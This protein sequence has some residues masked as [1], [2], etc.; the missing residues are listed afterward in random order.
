MIAV[1]VWYLHGMRPDDLPD[2]LAGLRRASRGRDLP[3]PTLLRSEKWD[4]LVRDGENE[5][6][7]GLVPLRAMAKT[8]RGI[9]TGANEFFHLTAAQAR[10][11]GLP[12]RSLLPCV[13]R[14]GDV[15]GFEFTEES[16]RRIRDG[17]ARCYLVSLGPD[18]DDAERRYIAA[19]ESEGIQSRYLLA[20]RRP[21]F[22]MERQVPAPVWAAVFGRQ[23][24]RFVH[25]RAGVRTL[26]T[27][28]CVYPQTAS[29]EFC[30]ALTLC[31]NA[32]STQNRARAQR[33]VYGGGLLKFEPKDLL[34]IEVPDLRRVS[35][36]ILAELAKLQAG[37]AGSAKRISETDWARADEA[38]REAAAEAA[39][40][41]ARHA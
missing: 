32:P 29:L 39:R 35:A 4:S 12:A 19:G 24:L 18:L 36:S 6:V 26:T 10:D 31:L 33:R 14:A 11:L 23:G 2:T 21:W 8:K 15:E 25:N 3:V 22:S 16:F 41:Q 17:G 9:A 40:S 13:G 28:H 20:A 34:D 37:F 38:V 1:R 27:F 30:A 7:P 5:A